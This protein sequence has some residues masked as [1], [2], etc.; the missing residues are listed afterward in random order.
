VRLAAWLAAWLAGLSIGAAC[1]LA[2]VSSD[3]PP[4]VVAS[5]IEAEEYCITHLDAGPAREAC[6]AKAHAAV[7]AY[8]DADVNC[9]GGR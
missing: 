8:W 6:R 5:T 1:P 7:C 4:V 9:R 2:C 3:P